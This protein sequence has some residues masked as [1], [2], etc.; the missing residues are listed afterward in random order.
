M[1]YRQ[2]QRHCD[3]QHRDQLSLIACLFSSSDGC[4]PENSYGS[5][6]KAQYDYHERYTTEH[7]T[8]P[9]S[10]LMDFGYESVYLKYHVTHLV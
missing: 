5:E 4:V 1:D 3:E 6:T 10:F 8:L 9:T 7:A 2:D